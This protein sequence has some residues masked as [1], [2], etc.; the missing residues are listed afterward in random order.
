MNFFWKFF[1]ASH[2]SYS[3]I[4]LKI[5]QKFAYCCFMQKKN[6]PQRENNYDP[7][8]L[9]LNAVERIMAIE[10]YTSRVFEGRWWTSNTH[11]W[12]YPSNKPRNVDLHNIVLLC[13]ADAEMTAFWVYARPTRGVAGTPATRQLYR[14][15]FTLHTHRNGLRK[16][17][18]L[19]GT[20]LH[21]W[22]IR[23]CGRNKSRS[24]EDFIII[25]NSF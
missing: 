17:H 19:R 9:H 12:K 25:S 6:R 15:M 4:A 5:S 2:R 22:I 18:F 8:N 1:L 11:L 21:E 23:V 3:K 14:Y 13:R 16:K 10:F 20:Y 7:R 24:D